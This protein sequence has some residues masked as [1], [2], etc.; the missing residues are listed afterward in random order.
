[1]YTYRAVVV[2][3]HDGDTLTAHVDAGF[4]TWQHSARFRLAGISA[5]ELAAPGGREA[6]DHLAGLLPAGTAVTIQSIKAGHD[7]ADD[8]SFD[9]YVAVVTLPDGRDLGDLLIQTGWAVPWNGRTK[10]VPYPAWPIA[11]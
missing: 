10:P 5:R 4:H 3:V 2:D 11:T 7:P 8:M 6:R 9:R 1:L